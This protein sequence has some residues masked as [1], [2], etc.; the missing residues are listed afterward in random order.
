MVGR[1]RVTGGVVGET[2]GDRTGGGE[3]EGDRRGGRGDRG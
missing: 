1:Y 2:E 3:T